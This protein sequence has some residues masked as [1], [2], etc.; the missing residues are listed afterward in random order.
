M[1]NIKIYFEDFDLNIHY[2]DNHFNFWY[3]Y[4]FERN[5]SYQRSKEV[6]LVYST[7]END[8]TQ[9]WY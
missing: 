6:I 2:Q 9:E 5:Q 4:D 1:N 3:S 7:K 8:Q